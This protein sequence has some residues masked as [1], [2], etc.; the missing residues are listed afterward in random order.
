VEDRL[1]RKTLL[2]IAVSL[3]LISVAAAVPP[4]AGG[5]GAYGA[6]RAEAER[7]YA[8][9]SFSRAHDLY[10]EAAKLQLTEE[11]AQWVQFRLGDTTWRADLASPDP[12]PKKRDAAR[13]A[14]EKVA[15]DT[16]YPRIAAEA[17]ESLGDFH[18][19]HPYQRNPGEAQ[20]WY[21]AA[22]DYW[23]GSDELALARG[24]YLAIFWRMNEQ[25]QYGV[26]KDVL[27]NAV[28]I[29]QTA[30]DRAHAK[31]LL[32]A[33]LLTEGGAANAERAF[34][35]FEE[36]LRDGRGTT[37]YDNTLWAYGEAL[38]QWSDMAVQSRDD[39]TLPPPDYAK[40]LELFRRLTREFSAGQS[41]FRDNAAQMIEQMTRVSVDVFVSA[42]FLPESEQEIGLSWRNARRIELALY[43]VD[44]TA[45]TQRDMRKDWKDSIS[46]EGRPVVRTWTHETHSEVYEPGQELLR[47]NPRLGPGAYIV[48]ARAE[49]GKAGRALLLVSD[50]HILVHAAGDAAKIF[51]SDVETG[52][53][54]ANARVR[55]SSNDPRDSSTKLTQTDANGLAEVAIDQHGLA[56]ITASAGSRQAYHLGYFSAFGRGY[57]G[58]QADWRVYAFTDRPAYRPSDTVQWKIIARAREDNRWI[59]PKGSVE[60]DIT[61]P[62]GEKVASGKAQLNEFGSFWSELAL[63]PA[64]A[65]GAYNI[66]FRIGDQHMG[67]AQLFRLEE[68]KLPEF[69]VTVATPEG[70]QYRLGDTIEATIDASYYFGG[71]VA[72]AEVEAVVYQEP[73]N[74]YWFPWRKY[75]WYWNDIQPPYGGDTVMSRETLRTDANGRAILHIPTPRDGNDTSYRIEARVV[76]ASRREVRGTGSVR[77]TRQRYTVLVQPE[78]YIHRPN[79]AASI[80][81]KAM[82]ANDKPVQTTGTV[83]VIRRRWKE[84]QYLDDEVLTTKLT[85]DAEGEATLTFTPKATGYYAIRWTSVDGDPKRA[86]DRVIAETT[87]WVADRTTTDLGYYHDAGGLD[88]I[89]DKEAMRAG[90]TA[91]VL[92]VTPSAGRW[93]LFTTSADTILDSRVIRMEGTAKLVQLELDDR[94]VP[95]FFV[96]ASSIFGR[97]FASK[98]ERIVVPPVEHFLDVEVKAD[99]EQYEPRQEGKLTITTRTVDGKPVPAEVALAVSDEAVTAIQQDMAGDPRQFFYGETN[100]SMLNVSAGVYS[101]RYV[102]LKEEEERRR[103]EAEEGDGYAL[104]EA[105]VEGRVSGGVAGGVVGGIPGGTFGGMVGGGA[106]DAVA[107]SITVTAAAPAMNGAPPPAPPPA[108]VAPPSEVPA[109]A[110]DVQVRNDFRSTAFWKPNVVTDANGTATVS[111]KYPEALTTWRATARAV[112]TGSSFG[113][114]SSTSRTN[115]PLLVRLQAPRFFVAGDRVVVSAV[116]NNNTDAAM[117]VTPSLDAE[118]VSGGGAATPVQ[119]PAHGESRVDWTVNAE[120]AGDA[121]LRVTARGAQH[122]DAMEKTFVVYEHG[123]DKLIA[124]SGKLRGSEALVRLELPRERRATDLTVQIAPSLAVTMLDALPYLLDFPYGCTEQTM[125]RFLPAAIVARTLAKLGLDPNDRLSKKKLDAVTDAGMARLYDMQHAN[126]AW[127]WWKEGP[128]D[129]WMTAYV[130]W[131]FA[132]ARE[133]GLPVD[134]NAVDRAAAWLTRRV[135][136]H[137]NEWNEQAWILHAL[138]AWR[139]KLTSQPERVAF[140]EI[141]TNRERLSAYSRALFALTAHRYGDSERAR[142]LVRNLE[143]GVKLDKTPD[144]SVLLKGETTAETMAT[145]HWGADR[146]WWRWHEGPIETT[147]FVLQALVTIDP[148]HPLIEPTMNWLVKNRRGAQWTNTRDT[149]IALLALNDYLEQSGELRGDVAYELSVNGRVVATKTVTAADVLRAPSRFSVDPAALTDTTQEVRIRRTGGT[150]P[151]YFSAE[152]RFVSLEEPVK[153]AGNEMFVR[154]EY[155]RLAPRPTLLKGVLYDK[156]P[157]RDGATIKSGERVEVVVTVDVKNDYEYLLFEDLKPAGLEAVELQSGQ[158]LYATNTATKRTAWVYQELRDRKVVLFVDHLQQGVWELRYTLRAEVPG[159]FHALPLL[160]Q[161][162]YVPDV[163]ANGE[164]VRVTVEENVER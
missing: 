86:R 107:Q 35:L 159:M 114:G 7:F 17:N 2:S 113:I 106:R 137:R 40:A 116:I 58:R 110:I 146:F 48:T 98:Q 69:V 96:T 19:T 18:G 90:E 117:S 23:A 34:E 81:F 39:D 104:K 42:T 29:A 14:L 120:R 70:T 38:V 127:G 5:E 44:L 92:I 136:E 132:V 147:A 91:P 62:R 61:S 55:T 164:E 21:V 60:Y 139:G 122:G 141:W 124:R 101:Q 37:W 65:L 56:L 3:L 31:F 143:D 160:G 11:E 134:E 82:D 125:S 150:G 27:V 66:N 63:T 99:R 28:K 25:N 67:S 111:F 103:E 36:I 158:P 95:N 77:V 46:I 33:R 161:A 6:L 130:V 108:P 75:P 121:K 153:A 152:A 88:L 115:L 41:E 118:G 76:D 83:E 97:Q 131:G 30:E 128:D 109:P 72:N 123:I 119:V 138:S 142:V 84:R 47:L 10:E 15:A 156:V 140:D 59:T 49:G 13:A 87:I 154:R 78:H 157:L 52:E 151:I 129:D 9:K 50:A 79:E 71:P 102:N 51:V 163:R 54:I 112:T 12:D 32:A 45:D 162:M 93:V 149:A 89:I 8:E 53:P 4:Q 155:F 68:Y 100:A 85:T 144:Q 43:S 74:R 145:A 135:V 133:G 20:R 94:H 22:L 73:L 80:R 126:G 57:R 105:G 16:R 26:P 24:R 1:A 64:M 148:Q